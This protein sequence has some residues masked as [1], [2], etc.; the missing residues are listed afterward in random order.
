MLRTQMRPLHFVGTARKDL[1]GFPESA[2]RR[3]GHELFMVQV[4]HA[5]QKKTQD[6]AKTDIDLAAKR[7]KLIEEKS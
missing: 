5:F 3:A 1:T 6:T 2:R 4:L 7:Y